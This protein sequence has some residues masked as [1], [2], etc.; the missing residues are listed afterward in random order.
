MPAEESPQTLDGSRQLPAGDAFGATHQGGGSPLAV[1]LEVMGEHQFAL[2]F[3]QGQHGI[4]E[5]RLQLAPE[6]VLSGIHKVLHGLVLSLPPAGMGALVS[7]SQMASGD[8]KPAT[9]NRLGWKRW[10]LTDQQQKHFLRCVLSQRWIVK[11][12]IAC[13]LYHRPM[14]HH[15]LSACRLTQGKRTVRHTLRCA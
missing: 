9:Q 5:Q 6:S 4:V 8:I 1:I 2:P 15:E 11:N 14:H 3:G 10:K 12:S 7:P 13:R